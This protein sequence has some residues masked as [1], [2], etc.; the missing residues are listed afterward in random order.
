MNKFLNVLYY[1][2]Y[3]FYTKKIPESDPHTTVIW[4]ISICESSLINA[5]LEIIAIRFYCYD[6]PIFIQLIVV[7]LFIII[8]YFIY[9][10]TNFGKLVVKQKP[11]LVNK[12]FS[13]VVSILFFVISISWWFWGSFYSRYLLSLCKWIQYS[14]EH[15]TLRISI[16]KK[17]PES[18][19]PLRPKHFIIHHSVF[20]CSIFISLIRRTVSLTLSIV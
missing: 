10:R 6:V 8:N 16:H 5:I 15:R 13:S 4:A 18:I 11:I 17:L 20:V 12:N 1:N 7:G 14:L 2:Y 9:Y 19:R 3:L